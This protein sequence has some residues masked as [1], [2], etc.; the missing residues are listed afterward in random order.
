MQKT[1]EIEIDGS[2]LKIESQRWARQSNGSVLVSLRDTRI[3]VTANM[4]DEAKQNQDF[5]LRNHNRDVSLQNLSLVQ[6][7]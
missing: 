7:L 3:L 1:V 4:R 5:L 6:F 2:K